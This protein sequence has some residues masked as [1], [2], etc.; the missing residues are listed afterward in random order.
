[1]PQKDVADLQKRIEAL[2][3]GAK[4]EAT[5][6]DVKAVEQEFLDKL[7]EIKA[8]MASGDSAAPAASSKEMEELKAENEILKKKNAKLEYRVQHM[9]KSMEELYNKQKQ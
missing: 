7:Q 5:Q 1:M 3:V 9:L 8:S 4:F 6:K 2:E